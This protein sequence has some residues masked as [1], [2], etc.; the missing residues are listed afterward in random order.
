[1]VSMPAGPDS[2]EPRGEGRSEAFPVDWRDW[3]LFLDIDGTLLGIAE[4]PGAVTVDRS[5]A[6]LLGRLQAAAAGAVA[7]ISGR[8]VADIDRLFAPLK[9]SVAGQHGLER[10][11]AEGRMH[12][13][14]LPLTAMESARAQLARLARTRA[15]V[16]VEDKGASLA[17]HYRAAPQ[18]GPELA[19]LVGDIVAGLGQQFELQPG[20][21]VLEVKPG[22]RDKGT[23]I[24]EFMQERPFLGR[25]PVFI[26]DDHT[27]EFGFALVNRTGGHSVKVGEGASAARW[28]LPD[29]LAVRTWL[30]K[31]AAPGA[32]AHHLSARLPPSESST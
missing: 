20:K 26:G 14:P 8:S 3:A 1:M 11:D 2:I 9:L 16:W 24:A 5:L 22:G 28:R 10:R 27:D 6:S 21:M 31:I 7:L 32:A 23:A 19:G 29:A 15:G 17:L 4:H 18:L 13:Q 30:E 12:R 25:T